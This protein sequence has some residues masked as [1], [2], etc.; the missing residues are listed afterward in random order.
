MMLNPVRTTVLPLPVDV[1]GQTEAGSEGPGIQL[2]KGAVCL[3]LYIARG[4]GKVEITGQT[5]RFVESGGVF[6]TEPEINVTR[7]RIRQSSCA[8]AAYSG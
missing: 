8:K 7:G 3:L 5:A 1:P 2:I 4:G 6:I